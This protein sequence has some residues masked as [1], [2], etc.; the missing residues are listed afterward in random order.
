MSANTNASNWHVIKTKPFFEKKAYANLDKKGFHV[1]LPLTE[2]MRQ[3]SDRK[4]KIQIPLIPSVVF[5]K[6]N[7]SELQHLYGEIGV[8]GVLKYLKKPAV[9]KDY[10]IKNLKILV[11]QFKGQVI[12]TKQES[13]L[14]GQLVEVIEG[15]FKGLLAE[16]VVQNG[17]HR[18]KVKI[19]VLNT[20]Y[21]VNIPYAF[22]RSLTSEVA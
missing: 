13:I 7:Q 5:I 14:P 12:S 11:D 22:V 19:S 15:P 9:V 18:I 3:W 10:E 21:M 6:C 1:F 8:L 20:E 4:K 17:K 2:T 16:S